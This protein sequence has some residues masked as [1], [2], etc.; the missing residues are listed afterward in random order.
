MSG[1][2][3][4]LVLNVHTPLDLTPDALLPVMFFIHGGGYFQGSGSRFIYGPNYLVTKGVILVTINYRLNIQ[5]FL[6]LGL[7]EAPG[8]AGMKDQVAALKWVQKNIRAFGGDP[9]NVTLF[10]E[11][12]G[13][14]SVSYHI[15]SPMSKGLFHKAIAQSGSSLAAWGCQYRPVYMASLIAKTMGYNTE[16]PHEL[17]KIFMNKTDDELIIT[18]VPRKKGNIILSELLYVPCVEK[19]VDGVEPF[20][21]EIPYNALE[22]GKYNKVPMI[23]GSN[24]EEGYC[25]VALENDTA[26][27]VMEFEK[28]IPKDLVIPSDKRKEIGVTLKKLYMGDEEISMETRLKL[29][30]FHGEVYFN[31]PGFEETELILR[32][33]NKPVYNYLFSYDG[34]RNILKLTLGSYFLGTPGAT[35]AD[36]LFYLFKTTSLPT[37]FDDKMIDRMTT[38]WTNFAKYG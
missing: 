38:M 16:D 4:C 37:L 25:F 7:K 17:Y 35:H 14:N 36:D 21:T 28:S 24:S 30:R 1:Q 18:R 15:L 23:I 27:A 32:T 26:L 2:E 19:K 6:C 33:S 12:A 13:A 22:N 20:M 10:G 29:S 5:G 9:D 8:N 3:N 31:Y 11:S 34:W